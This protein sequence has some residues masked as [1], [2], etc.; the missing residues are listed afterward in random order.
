MIST[1]LSH[2]CVESKKAKQTNKTE[3]NSDTD[4]WLPEGREVEVG[5]K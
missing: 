4:R 5:M 3:T 1:M 2:F